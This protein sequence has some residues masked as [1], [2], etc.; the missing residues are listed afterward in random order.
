MQAA[1]LCG[2]YREEKQLPAVAQAALLPERR[3]KEELL[4]GLEPSGAAFNASIDMRLADSSL[5]KG[6]NN[7]QPHATARPSSSTVENK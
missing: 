2:R 4:P 5:S 6:V 3:R 7:N 1:L